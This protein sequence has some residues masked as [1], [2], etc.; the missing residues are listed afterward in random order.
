MTSTSPARPAGER[1]YVA[2]QPPATMAAQLSMVMSDLGDP[3]PIPHVTVLAPPELSADLEWIDAVREAAAN[4]AS[5]EVTLGGPRTFA[6]GVL[7]LA[8][9]SPGL[10]VLRRDLVARLRALRAPTSAVCRDRPYVTH[11][12]LARARPGAEP[13]R[14]GDVAERV[15]DLGPFNATAL[16][17]FRR[18]EGSNYAVWTTAPYTGT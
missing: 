13:Q 14:W 9:S 18:D 17:V 4:T 11:L 10:E 6:S 7:Y 1:F 16:T 15:G 5:V 3:W 12:T 2:V 8:V